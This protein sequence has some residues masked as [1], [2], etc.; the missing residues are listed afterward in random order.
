MRSTLNN[1]HCFSFSETSDRANRCSITAGRLISNHAFRMLAEP[2]E[3][4]LLSKVC[5]IPHNPLSSY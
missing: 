4:C 5:G 2:N 1:L 3:S